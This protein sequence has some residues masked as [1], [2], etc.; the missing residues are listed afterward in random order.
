MH[1]LS[2]AQAIVDRA[3]ETADEHGAREVE[4]LT[5]ELGEATHVNPDQ[6]QFCIET[7]AA[8]SSMENATVTIEPVEPRAACDCGWQGEP[9]EFD[10]TAAVVPAARC[11]E[12]G[13]GT[14]FTQG[15]ECRLAS[16][17]VPDSPEAP[18]E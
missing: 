14:E 3:R 7:V 9:P 15:T 11:P 18:T 4:T 13:S 12:C 16:I 17:E 1:E 8:E 2:V 10:G 5:V 6:L